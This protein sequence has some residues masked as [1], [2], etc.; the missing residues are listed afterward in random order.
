MRRTQIQLPDSLYDRL[1]RLA[2]S[3][4]TTLS[5]ILRRAAEYLLSVHPAHSRGKAEW[6]SPQPID[7]GAFLA[8]EAD[9]RARGNEPGEDRGNAQR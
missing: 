2:R 5:D 4:E 9:W 6:Q 7:L 1:K 8:P 3:Q